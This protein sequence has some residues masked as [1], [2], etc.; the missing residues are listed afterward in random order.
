MEFRSNDFEMFIGTL[1]YE[2]V[3]DYDFL[4]LENV[5]PQFAT[6]CVD[7]SLPTPNATWQCF[8]F[9]QGDINCQKKSNQNKNKAKHY[10]QDFFKRKKTSVPQKNQQTKK[11]SVSLKN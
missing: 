3:D 1:W 2:N 7:Y 8:D 6:N 10:A 4:G 11:T 9:L 5:L